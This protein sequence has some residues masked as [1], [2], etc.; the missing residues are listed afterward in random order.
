MVGQGH[1]AGFQRDLFPGQLFLQ[2]SGHFGS[3]LSH[4]GGGI[5][6][7]DDMHVLFE[8]IGAGV[9]H[10]HTGDDRNSQFVLHC[11]GNGAAGNAVTAGIEGGAG[12]EAVR[13]ILA[14]KLKKLR[15]NALFN[16]GA[17]VVVAADDCCDYLVTLAQCRFESKAR[18][19]Y[20]FP[21]FGGDVGLFLAAY[22]GKELVYIMNDSFRHSW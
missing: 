5:L 13:L 8:H 21:Y 11:L 4:I 19:N 1:Y 10:I 15:H 3:G 18:A 22:S 14:N 6:G 20:A 12:D 2:Q 16:V 9:L 7:G 17:K